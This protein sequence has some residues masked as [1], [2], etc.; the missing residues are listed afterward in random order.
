MGLS[1]VHIAE[2]ALLMGNAFAILNEKRVLKRFGLDRAEFGGEG[3][4]GSLKN[5]AATFL[6]MMR[7]FMLYPLVACNVFFIIYE[8][9]LG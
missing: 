5:Q 9:L 7:T 6:H 4:V 8:L 2:A 3:G 1:L